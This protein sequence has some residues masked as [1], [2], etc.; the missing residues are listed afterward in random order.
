LTNPL[1]TGFVFQLEPR[2]SVVCGWVVPSM[3]LLRVEVSLEAAAFDEVLKILVAA[4]AI[5]FWLFVWF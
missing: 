1:L 3:L 4:I 2:R 5:C